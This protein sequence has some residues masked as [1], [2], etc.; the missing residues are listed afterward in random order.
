MAEELGD[1]AHPVLAADE[2]YSDTQSQALGGFHAAL[3]QYRQGLGLPP[4][5]PLAFEDRRDFSRKIVRDAVGPQGLAAASPDQ[6]F[7]PIRAG[8]LEIRRLRLID[9]FGRILD[10]PA[11]TSHGR[12]G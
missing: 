3:L 12:R 11:K 8:R 6:P 9:A 2:D 5:D 7:L 10:V 4:D 1:K